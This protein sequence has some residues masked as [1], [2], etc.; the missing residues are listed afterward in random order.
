MLRQTVTVTGHVS[1]DNQR[2]SD[3]REAESSAANGIPSSLL[4]VKGILPGIY[5]YL[6]HS[7]VLK[8]LDFSEETALT[9]EVDRA[10]LFIKIGACLSL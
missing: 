8:Y 3:Q 5:Y 9:G 4:F 1:A 7:D 2:T 10:I 6:C